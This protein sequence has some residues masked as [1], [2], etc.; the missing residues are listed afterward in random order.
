MP[1]QENKSKIHVLDKLAI[2][3]EAKKIIFAK[4]DSDEITPEHA[5]D[6]LEYVKD[7]VVFVDTPEQAAEYVE[8]ICEKYEELSKMKLT[9]EKQELEQLEKTF[10]TMVD[11]LMD[12]GE[13]DKAEEL[14]E[15]L[16]VLDHDKKQFL[17][18][19]REKYPDM[20]KQ[21]FATSEPVE[22]E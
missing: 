20:F 19:A 9:F 4:M 21:A 14:I 22:E 18:D 16:K 5:D 6:I 12:E 17:H 7:S 13:F 2:W 1:H 8:E 10:M 15:E 3:S 11:Q